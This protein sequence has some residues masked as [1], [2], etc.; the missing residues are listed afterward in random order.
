MAFGLGR[1]LE[2]LIPNTTDKPVRPDPV[3]ATGA[4]E[5]EIAAIKPNPFQPRK[6][7]S[8][9]ELED[10]ASS[11][12]EHG[13]LEPLV[14]S[15]TARTGA[16][17]LVA[18]ERRLRAAELAGLA[19]VPVVIRQTDDQEKLELALIENIQR[20]DLNP[21]EEARALRKLLRDFS[22]SQDQ[23]AKRVGRSRP[24]VANCVRLLEL[25][26]DVQQALL[27]SQISSGHAKCMVVLSREHQIALLQEIM[28]EGL[29]VRQTE[30]RVRQLSRSTASGSIKSGGRPTGDA[31]TQNLG[32]V[33]S[34]HLGAKVEVSP[35]A[36]SGKITIIY[37]SA[38]ERAR[39]VDKI[40][41]EPEQQS[42]SNL[43]ERSEFTV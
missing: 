3:V 30:A 39:I 16:Y 15:P 14:I 34:Q 5:I 25:S 36:N 8:L 12:R 23:V 10:L 43:R 26:S 1:G 27:S 11:I 42:S 13:I 33:L 22:L 17:T 2:A 19:T 24:A 38:E 28:R 4:L 35:G 6:Q 9:P 29:S 32:R 31:E 41:G 21:L 20:Q 7:F 18:G 40:I 37:H